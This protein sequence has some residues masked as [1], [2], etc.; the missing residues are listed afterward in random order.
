MSSGGRAEEGYFDLL[1]TEG[2]LQSDKPV[3]LM[4][5]FFADLSPDLGFYDDLVLLPYDGDYVQTQSCDD[6]PLLPAAW[7]L[8]YDRQRAQR[9]D[10]FYCVILMGWQEY[11]LMATDHG[12]DPGELLTVPFSLHL[13]GESCST[14]RKTFGIARDK[15]NDFDAEY[16][17]QVPQFV[18]YCT[19]YDSVR[20]Y[21]DWDSSLATVESVR[22]SPQAEANGMQLSVVQDEPG[23][24]EVLVGGGQGIHNDTR[25]FEVDYRLG[26]S[27]AAFSPE[28]DFAAQWVNSGDWGWDGT[29]LARE[30][31]AWIRIGCEKGDVY[32]DDVVD[33]ID[34]DAA[35]ALASGSLEADDMTHCRADLNENGEADAGDGVLFN[36]M[37]AGL[38]AGATGTE[39]CAYPD[40]L[41]DYDSIVIEGAAGA[42]LE[43]SFDPTHQDVAFVSADHGK[44]SWSLK[45]PGLLHIAWAAA[46][47]GT[48]HIDPGFF[49]SSGEEA[50]ALSSVRAFDETGRGI[51]RG[52]CVATSAPAKRVTLL[53]PLHPNPFNPRTTVSFELAQ[54]GHVEVEIYDARGRMLKRL[55]EG[56]LTAGPHELRWDGRDENGARLASGVYRVLLSTAGGTQT[57]AAVLVK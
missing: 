15:L 47:T 37:I 19:P 24:L 5:V 48:V 8:P 26:D 45:E 1:N 20:A 53:H 21:L 10:D 28:T 11:A 16:C 49:V 38:T 40:P 6:A 50:Y 17:V 3:L 7:N 4:T 56:Q 18:Q 33:E 54:A 31:P 13:W 41:D 42:E 39:A 55:F 35:L 12:A 52:S 23:H 46:S 32:D 14:D 22:L 44:L 43:L 57:R 51:P 2:C 9:T 27:P 36:R 30:G 25:I 29:L 34:R